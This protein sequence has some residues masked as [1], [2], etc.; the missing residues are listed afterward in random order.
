MT[1]TTP[2]RLG[3]G[4][5]FDAAL[6]DYFLTAT[7]A[8]ELCCGRSQLA[9]SAFYGMQTASTA[10]DRDGR[11]EPVVNANGPCDFAQ[12]ERLNHLKRNRGDVPAAMARAS[13]R[14][15]ASTS[16][17]RA[18][19]KQTVTPDG[20]SLPAFADAV[21]SSGVARDTGVRNTRDIRDCAAGRVIV[22]GDLPLPAPTVDLS[23]VVRDLPDRQRA[24]AER[25]MAGNS[26]ADIARADG[27]SRAAITLLCNKIRA[28]LLTADP[29]LAAAYA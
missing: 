10:F 7:A 6:D 5:A 1:T 29:S 9:L 17:A 12:T 20:C 8:D 11:L 25:L 4:A 13:V 27:V 24:V 3:S 22:N 23:L 16:R 18:C 2:P 19:E 15:H 26:A 21:F 14:R 28:A